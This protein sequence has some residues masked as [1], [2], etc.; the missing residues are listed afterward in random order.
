[1]TQKASLPSEEHRRLG[2]ITEATC[3]RRANTV[4]VTM[5]GSLTCRITTLS[6]SVVM[7]VTRVPRAT[8]CSLPTGAAGS[9]AAGA[10]GSPAA[11]AKA[12]S[13]P[14]RSGNNGICTWRMT[15]MAMSVAGEIQANGSQANRVTSSSRATMSRV[16]G[17]SVPRSGL[18]GIFTWRTT[19]MATSVV[20]RATQVTEDVGKC[21]LLIEISRRDLLAADFSVKRQLCE[22]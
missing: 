4:M 7:R 22:V 2:M 1:M 9:P 19:A 11:G 14:P 8:G 3:S 16:A 10:A 17:S 13:F 21:S 15:R 12:T 18:V 20:G 6:M 5:D